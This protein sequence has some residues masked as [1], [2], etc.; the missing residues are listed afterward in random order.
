MTTKGELFDVLAGINWNH[1]RGTFIGYDPETQTVVRRIPTTQATGFLE[2]RRYSIKDNRV[3]F[4]R[5]TRK[6]GAK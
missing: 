5:H 2:K 3:T 1:G 6:L 4:L